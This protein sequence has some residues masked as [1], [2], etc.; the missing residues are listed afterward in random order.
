MDALDASTRPAMLAEV[1]SPDG[2]HVLLRHRLL[3]QP[4]GFGG[5]GSDALLATGRA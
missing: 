2:V 5:P 4:H 1:E 3:R